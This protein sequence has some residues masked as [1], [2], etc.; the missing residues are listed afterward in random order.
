M[1]LRPL[2]TTLALLL[3]LT[4]AAPACNL[5]AKYC[6]G[7]CLPDSGGLTDATTGDLGASETGLSDPTTG[8][9]G[10]PQDPPPTC[11]LVDTIVSP[12]TC[13]DKVVQPGELCFAGGGGY[14]SFLGVVS[15]IA[16]PLQGVSTDLLIVREDHTV[17]AMLFTKS[18][19]L[20]SSSKDWPMAFPDGELILTVVGDFNE[21]GIA[22]VAGRLDG[23]EQD[24]I[25]ILLLDGTGGLLAAETVM[26]GAE[27]HGPDLYDSQDDDHLDLLVTMPKEAQLENAVVLH[28]D[29]DGGFV[30]ESEFGAGNLERLHV[31]GVLGP[32]GIHNDLVVAGDDGLDLMLVGPGDT[33]LT[34]P[35][36][37]GTAVKD[38]AVADVNDDGLGDI[39]ALVED[40]A[41]STSEVVVFT[42]VP[43]PDDGA[44]QFM[45][46]HYTVHCGA[47][48]LVVADIDADGVPDL[49]TAGLGDNGT[50]PLTIRRNDGAGGF[51]DVL[52]L[53]IEGPV[54][55]LFVADLNGDGAPDIADAA[56]SIGAIG[57]IPAVP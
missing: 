1:K 23:Y 21:D 35:L 29:G 11:D 26:A 40:I 39:V 4:A 18:E 34:L 54:T 32:D 17:S 13:F 22:D 25:V 49:A 50:A 48:E 51:A 33:L 37:Q 28:G 56:R 31:T 53:A 5:A 14:F 10:S 52:T 12:A 8:D 9:V 7:D 43:G 46:A 41:F 24:T 27:L 57:L 44:P 6:I 42:R 30:A 38:L 16:A 19:G 3:L 2:Y 36:Q 47:T 15:M 20:S 55:D 45:P